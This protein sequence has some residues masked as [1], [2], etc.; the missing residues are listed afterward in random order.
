LAYG[1]K[2]IDEKW[3][4]FYE[5]HFRNMTNKVKEIDSV[6]KIL[7]EDFDDIARLSED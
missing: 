5:T 4:V 1:F 3:R 2:E 6:Y 7:R